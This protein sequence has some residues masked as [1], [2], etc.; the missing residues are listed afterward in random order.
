MIAISQRRVSLLCLLLIVFAC[1][2]PASAADEPAAA[3][4]PN[5]TKSPAEVV[6]SAPRGSLKNP[7]TNNA[8]RIAEGKELFQSYSCSGCHG[9]TG[10][11]GMCPPVNG[12]VWFYGMQDDTLYRLITLGSVEMQKAG[13]DRLGGP[14]L[15]M[16]PFGQIIKTDDEVWKIIAWIRSVYSGDPKKK[17]W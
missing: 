5:A 8:D 13:F 10:G 9:G 6:K 16:P 11:G 15:Q 1:S 7:Y 12:D 4:N 17:F 14:G 2:S 3:A